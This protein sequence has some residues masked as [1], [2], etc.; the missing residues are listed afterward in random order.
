M[1]GYMSVLYSDAGAKLPKQRCSRHRIKRH[2]SKNVLSPIAATVVEL[3][4][5]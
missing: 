4:L 2:L 3:H 1:H 5:V